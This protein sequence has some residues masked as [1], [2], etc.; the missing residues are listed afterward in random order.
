MHISGIEINNFLSFQAFRWADVDPKLNIVVGPNGAGKTNLFHAIRAVFNVLNVGIA[1]DQ[2]RAVLRTAAYGADVDSAIRIVLHVKFDT[3][4]EQTLIRTFLIAA[5]LE[6][7]H[8]V[9]LNQQEHERLSTF[10]HKNLAELDVSFLLEGRLVI[11]Y[12]P[13]TAWSAWYE[14]ASSALSFKWDLFPFNTFSAIDADGTWEGPYAALTDSYTEQERDA[15]GWYMKGSS[16]TFH[17]PT[18]ARVLAKQGARLEVSGHN[19]DPRQTYRAFARI[20]GLTGLEQNVSYGGRFI[21]HLMLE[22]GLIFTDNVRQP[23]TYTATSKDLTTPVV[24]LSNAKELPLYLFHQKTWL[25]QSEQY[26]RIQDTFHRLTNTSFDVGVARS[27]QKDERASTENSVVLEL[28][29]DAPWGKVPLEFSGAGRTE[30]LFL[31]AILA[32]REEK[33]VLLDEPAQNLHPNIQTRLMHEM[34]QGTASQFFVVTHSPTFIPAHAIDKVSRFHTSNNTTQRASLQFSI[35]DREYTPAL[36]KELRGSSDARALLFARGVM[37]VEGDTEFG[38]LPVWYD[39]VFSKLLESDDLI[40]YNVDGDSN[41]GLYVRFLESYAVPWVIQCDGA[42]IGDPAIQDRKRCKIAEQ[43]Q[44]AGV[45]DVPDLTDQDF[46]GRCSVLEQHGVFT[47]A[48]SA[49]KGE[50][51]FEASIPLIR[52]NIDALLLGSSK[53]RKAR[54]IAENNPCPDEAKALLQKMQTCLVERINT[55]SGS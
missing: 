27:A 17:A 2:R 29:T 37:L 36:Q 32:D 21:F 51:S 9:V 28:T 55:T 39:E 7:D 42:I 33:V 38:A 20:A 1:A 14:S 34:Q 8:T 6:E 49:K 24:D 13:M 31:S 15:F 41:F 23:L 30:A 18:M 52:D 53:P 44:R 25:T 19:S 40:M 43:L 4:W 3:A 5:L 48:T 45:S 54:S 12:D 46:S 11:T 50:E 26:K 35:R 22:R 16:D 10:W 47:V